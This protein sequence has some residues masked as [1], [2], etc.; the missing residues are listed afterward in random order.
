MP[1]CKDCDW[2]TVISWNGFGLP[3]CLYQVV[4]DE[5]EQRIED[6]HS[7]GVADDE[8]AQKASKAAVTARTARGAKSAKTPGNC[9]CLVK[10]L[11][12]FSDV[13]TRWIE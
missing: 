8:V 6:T 7:K 1:V 11:F 13:C 9:Y 12:Y 4:I 10:I 5:F 3:C 2:K